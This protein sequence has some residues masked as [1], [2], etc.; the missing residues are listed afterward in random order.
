MYQV[1]YKCKLCKEIAT[2]EIPDDEIDVK[3]NEYPLRT[4]F[5]MHK[6]QNGSVGVQEL[7]GYAIQEKEN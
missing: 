4:L 3:E 5:R 2:E 6:C 7:L 1:V